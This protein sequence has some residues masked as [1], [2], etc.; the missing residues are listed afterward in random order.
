MKVF[1]L[2]LLVIM[3]INLPTFK[4]VQAEYINPQLDSSLYQPTT[5]TKSIDRI[6]FSAVQRQQ[7]LNISDQKYAQEFAYF[8]HKLGF[9]RSPASY[10]LF[11]NGNVV[12]MN[13]EWLLNQPPTNL[14]SGVI[15]VLLVYT[16][17]FTLDAFDTA[18]TEFKNTTLREAVSITNINSI[19][20]IELRPFIIESGEDMPIVSFKQTEN[21]TDLHAKLS[22]IDF[23]TKSLPELAITNISFPEKADPSTINRAS[24]TI[25][26]N[27]PFDYVF[28]EKNYIQFRFDKDS[29]FF[30]NNTWLNQ[31]IPIL[32]NDGPIYAKEAKT[33]DIELNI[34][35]MPGRINETI[36]I[37]ASGKI[38]GSR[39]INIIVNDVGQKILKVRPTELNYLNIR[40]EPNQAS[41][42]VGRA[43]VGSVYL[44]TETQ[45]NFYRIIFNGNQTGWVSAR[46]VEVLR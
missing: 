25:T 43:S 35:V 13:R 3:L 34:P 24:I 4:T 5:E 9:K 31:R 38:L 15:F 41:R 33:F 44:Y 30:V 2:I 32:Y 45:N 21:A 12:T 26:N 7:I 27:S 20:D 19:Q 14:D 11:D 36:Q 28:G 6:V 39:E 10:I 22:D 17:T 37:E 18:L 1:S 16:D 29:A 8:F 40:Q 42:E 23:V 46:Y